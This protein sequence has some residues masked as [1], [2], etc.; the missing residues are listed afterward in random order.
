MQ[1]GT[2]AALAVLIAINILNF[3]DR[4]VTGA[5]AMPRNV[6]INAIMLGLSRSEAR[7]R[8]LGLRWPIGCEPL[9]DCAQL[10]VRA[11]GRAPG[12]RD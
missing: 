5:L 12:Q 1:K 3:Y 6:I 2:K 10:I 8:L 4:N 7:E 11:L 9:T